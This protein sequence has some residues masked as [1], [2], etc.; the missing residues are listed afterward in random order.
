MLLTFRAVGPRGGLRHWVSIPHQAIQGITGKECPPGTCKI[1]VFMPN[2]EP[3]QLVHILG[4]VE[5]AAEAINKA[6][7]RD[8]IGR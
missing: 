4:E 8:R 1:E 7:I 5:S 2:D 3:T 6:E